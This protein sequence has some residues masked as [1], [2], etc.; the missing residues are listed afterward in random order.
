MLQLERFNNSST[1]L[2]GIEESKIDKEKYHQKIIRCL[3][4]AGWL[5]VI[6]A[7]FWLYLARTG[8]NNGYDGLFLGCMVLAILFGSFILT[9]AKSPYWLKTRNI[10]I[11]AVAAIIFIAIIVFIPL[12]FAYTICRKID[13]K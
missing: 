8:G 1:F 9:T 2:F 11:L 7:A 4:W 6:P 10:F 5:C 3:R 12:Y 13:V